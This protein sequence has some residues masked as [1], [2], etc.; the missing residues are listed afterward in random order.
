MS[1]EFSA[2]RP[3]KLQSTLNLQRLQRLRRRL[4]Q[5]SLSASSWLFET[6]KDNRSQC[7]QAQHTRVTTDMGNI[8]IPPDSAEPAP[9]SAMDSGIQAA[10][11]VVLLVATSICLLIAWLAKYVDVDDAPGYGQAERAATA[12]GDAVPP[13]A[14][15][16]L[17]AAPSALRAHWRWLDGIII[18]CR[19]FVADK[20]DIMSPAEHPASKSAIGGLVVI[21]FALVG[22]SAALYMADTKLP[23][24]TLSVHMGDG[25]LKNDSPQRQSAL[26]GA[27]SPSWVQPRREVTLAK[28]AKLSLSFSFLGVRNNSICRDYCKAAAKTFLT[29]DSEFD[30]WHFYCHSLE[31]SA[32]QK[33][34]AAATGVELQ[35]EKAAKN[36]QQVAQKVD[37]LNNIPPGS[38]SREFYGCRIHF[39]AKPNNQVKVLNVSLYQVA[40]LLAGPSFNHTLDFVTGIAAKASDPAVGRLRNRLP[41][42]PTYT[43]F[44]RSETTSCLPVLD[45]QV[46]KYIPFH[47]AGN[48]GIVPSSTKVI[49]LVLHTQPWTYC[50]GNELSWALSRL[51]KDKPAHL[52]SQVYTPVC[53][54]AGSRICWDWSPITGKTDDDS[55][56]IPEPFG[57]DS[58]LSISAVEHPGQEGDLVRP[59]TFAMIILIASLMGGLST[60]F[61]GL[62]SFAIWVHRKVVQPGKRLARHVLRFCLAFLLQASATVTMYVVVH[63]CLSIKPVVEADENNAQ[64]DPDDTTAV[65]SLSAAVYGDTNQLEYDVVMQYAA[66]PL[67]QALV[68]WTTVIAFDCA[69]LMWKWWRR[70][71][72]AVTVLVGCG[73][74]TVFYPYWLYLVGSRCVNEV[75]VDNESYLLTKAPEYQTQFECSTRAVVLPTTQF[76]PWAAAITA[77]AVLNAYIYYR[78]TRVGSLDDAVAVRLD[79]GP[80]NE[81]RCAVR[82]WMLPLARWGVSAAS[83]LI[84]AILVPSLIPQS[85]VFPQATHTMSASDKEKQVLVA[86]LPVW[87]SLA[88]FAVCDV[89]MAC[90]RLSP[91]RIDAPAD[92]LRALLENHDRQDDP[93]A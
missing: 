57:P 47:P 91:K 81:S 51:F 4:V 40:E 88:L 84:V 72:K 56:P 10:S 21:L 62:R 93:Q 15:P 80:R 75:E 29:V 36:L 38:R 5:R 65:Q 39:S 87:L 25:I 9:A 42:V 60:V 12:N 86:L 77:N 35:F 74:V 71:C 18:A 43:L 17:A 22:V 41:D 68:V 59:S 90:K 78:L 1:P 63:T 7:L 28:R 23:M 11:V 19:Q 79:D 67:L 24:S 82:K 64:D 45:N 55:A 83:A 14:G 6:L 30:K 70:L 89:V 32:L 2:R 31:K 33:H 66:I 73:F 76:I 61:R 13:A 52:G 20:L 85:L 50:V 16:A 8:F 27:S 69:E 3:K 34:A 48:P 53:Q 49:S 44:Q 58:I 46:H 26:Y 37:K 54:K 92:N